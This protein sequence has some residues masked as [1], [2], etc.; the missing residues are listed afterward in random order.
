MSGIIAIIKKELARFFFDRRMLVT[1]L[2]MPGLL[3]YVVYT[4]MGTLISD[5]AGGDARYSAAVKNMP[6]VLTAYFSGSPFDISD[7]SESDDAYKMRI[8]EGSLD[9][10]VL[11]P[12]D[13]E[14]AVASAGEPGYEAP[15]VEIYYSSSSDDSAAAFAAFSA[16]LDLYEQAI[17]NV[18]NV[19]HGDGYDLGTPQSSAAYILSAIVPMIMLVL[20]FSG[21]MAVAPESIAGEKERGTLATMLVTP[22]KRSHIAIG[23]IVSLSCIALLSG[24]CSFIGLILSLPNLM[25]GVFNGIDLSMFGLG[26]YM[27]MLGVMLSTVLLLIAAISCVSAM[28]KSVKEATTYVGPLSV[29]VVVVGLL[30]SLLGRGVSQ[31]LCLIPVYNSA[32]TMTGIMSLSVTP[33]GFILTIVSN[34]VYAGMLV[35]LLTR[36]FKSEKIMFDK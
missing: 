17:S 21:C 32:I 11:F 22:V 8:V 27:M 5:I 9:I 34:V 16:V 15:N 3:I 2:I 20:L 6:E 14:D 7:A 13:F 36:M 18:F 10:F 35:F 33:L 4:L 24:I 26:H 30:S 23:K 12:E 1:T 31:W 19:N 29:V 25:K 28:A